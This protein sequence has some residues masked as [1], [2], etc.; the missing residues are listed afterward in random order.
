M[1]KDACKYYK[2]K[3]KRVSTKWIDGKNKHLTKST[4][5]KPKSRGKN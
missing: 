3:K 1:S 2:K 4:G 5:K